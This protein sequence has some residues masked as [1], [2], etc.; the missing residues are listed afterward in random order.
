M[1]G[2]K[3]VCF[4]FFSHGKFLKHE[5]LVG[6][7]TVAAIAQVY[8]QPDVLSIVCDILGQSKCHLSSIA[9]WADQIRDSMRWSGALHFVNA[10]DDNPPQNCLFPGARG[11]A[12]DP[13]SNV[14]DAI[15]NVTNVLESW[16]DKKASDGAA[17]EALKFLVHFMG[18]MHQPLH[19]TGREQGGNRVVVQFDGKQASGYPGL[20]LVWINN[21]L[22]FR[23]SFRLGQLPYRKIHPADTS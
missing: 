13:H 16:V 20:E 22:P 7:G 18:D 12:G 5:F 1:H 17:E 19:L 9:S 23:S 10:V 14:L 11:W 2:V 8:L 15:K 4:F 3:K 21:S 6:H